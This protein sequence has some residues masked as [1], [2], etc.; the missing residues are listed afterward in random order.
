LQLSQAAPDQPTP[1]QTENQRGA[2]RLIAGSKS[3]LQ[4]NH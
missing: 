4:I 2:F 1:H 3:Y